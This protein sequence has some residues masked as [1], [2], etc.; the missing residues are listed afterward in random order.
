[1]NTPIITAFASLIQTQ[2]GE[3]QLQAPC[4]ARIHLKPAAKILQLQS[5]M[6]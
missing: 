2:K 6:H 5:V 3:R 4:K 1:M